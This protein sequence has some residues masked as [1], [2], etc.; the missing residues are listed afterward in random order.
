MRNSAKKHQ[1]WTSGTLVL[2]ILAGCSFLP[3]PMTIDLK[4]RLGANTSGTVQHEI[5]AGEVGDIDFRHP[6]PSGECIDFEDAEIPV[7]VQ[8]ARLHYNANVDYQGPPLTGMVTAQLYVA[9]DE[10]SLWSASNKVGPKVN[11]NLRNPDNRLAGTAV[12]NRDQVAGINSRFLC[13]GLEVTGS[14]VTADRSGEATIEYRIDQLRLDIR[15][16]VI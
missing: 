11:V 16:S 2:L 14:D 8:S 13:Y 9:R 3:L 15:F 6:D 5:G 4:T 1:L 7:T 12:L 10:A